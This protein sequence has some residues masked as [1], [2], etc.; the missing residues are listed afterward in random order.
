MSIQ[1]KAI[2]VLGLVLFTVGIVLGM[3]LFATAAWG[4]FEASLFDLSLPSDGPL[5]TLSC[6]VLVTA[7]ESGTVSATFTNPSERPIQRRV[8]IHVSDGLVTLLREEKSML[9]LDPGE[10]QRLQWTVTADD[11]VWG[12]LI[13]ARV[14]V[15]RQYPLPSAT[16]AC[17]IL[18]VDLPPFTGGHVLALAVAA[19]LLGIGLG[20]WLWMASNRPLAGRIRRVTYGMAV[21]AGIV[22]AGMSASLLGW[23]LLAV[24]LL[25]L[26]ILL[27]LAL[28]A[29][30]LL[31]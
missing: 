6:P 20:G 26:A 25:V 9:P 7:A 30:S 4:D 31:S 13:L 16:A 22:L 17:G 18:L 5:N 29:Y 1:R 12:R 15:Y 21:L 24:G 23:W 11:A 28:F 3:A 19:S 10:R 27:A 14:Y 2:R 8:R